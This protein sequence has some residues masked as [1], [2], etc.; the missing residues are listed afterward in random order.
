MKKP[1]YRSVCGRTEIKANVD[2]N[3]TAHTLIKINQYDKAI[4]VAG[5]GDYYFLAKYLLRN[6]KLYKILLPHK[7]DTSNLFKNDVFK[8]RIVY[9]S[10][11]KNV[12]IKTNGQA[13]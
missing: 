4:I 8:N 5:D 9:L 7:C 12:L 13:L 2:C 10:R 1:A 3:L 6:N 11:L